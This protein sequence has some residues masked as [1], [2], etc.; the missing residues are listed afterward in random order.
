M[1][2]MAGYVLMIPAFA[3]FYDRHATEFF[4]STAQYEA[5]V[6]QDGADL[7]TELERSVK[8]QF[9]ARNNGPT[10]Q[11][12]EWLVNINE[13]SINSAT[14]E[15][16][17]LHFKAYMRFTSLNTTMTAGPKDFTIDVRPTIVVG[18]PGAEDQYVLK[19]LNSTNESAWPVSNAAV[20]QTPQNTFARN[21]AIV[22]SPDLQ[23]RITNQ[24]YSYRGFPAFS[25][26]ASQ[27]MLYFSAVTQTTLGYGDI[28]PISD[29][30]RL[31]VAL[32]TVLGIVM[33]GLFLNSLSSGTNSP[34]SLN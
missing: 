34:K 8:D 31:A 2:F 26:G 9:I 21:G 18:F 33:I 5:D 29:R 20:F 3:L 23:D 15:D 30:T 25:S 10:S 17:R 12:G 11:A 16:G 24:S 7:L 32:Q 4:H 14:F 13:F 6:R 28:V 27:R 1:L 22:V 19:Y